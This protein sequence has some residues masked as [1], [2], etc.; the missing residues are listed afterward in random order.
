MSN[1]RRSQGSTDDT[2]SERELE[3]LFAQAK[4]RLL[5]PGLD[6]EDI[7]RAVYAEWDAVTRR[8][9]HA[10]R[11]GFAAAASILIAVALWVG[12]APSSTDSPAVAR[13]ERVEGLID[14]A[15]GEPLVVGSPLAAGGVLATGTGQIALRLASGGSLRV[16]AQSRV[17]LTGADAVELLAG[18]VYFDSED[19]RSGAAFKVT[20]DLGSMRDVGTQFLARLDPSAGR[21][22]VGVRDGRVELTR[23]DETG[24]AGVGERL[25][26]TEDARSIRRETVA[27]AGA[28]WDWAERVAPRF[29]IDG[30]TVGDFLAW[31]AAQTGRNVVFGS[32]AAERIAQGTV[33]SGSIDLAPLQKLSAVLAL[34]DLT[35]VLE[36]E[37]VVINTR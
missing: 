8:R 23:G 4:P 16:R 12:F 14:G 1:D 26:V 37:R 17:V 34:T 9:V 11:A 15:A 6:A 7:R 32:P 5:P 35:Y 10:R 27:T 36:G 33:L 24:T 13:V 25:I 3:R 19:A 2:A 30:R 20:T 29:D 31:F 28:D 21:L 18:A 22:D